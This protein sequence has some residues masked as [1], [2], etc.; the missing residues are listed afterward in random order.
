MNPSLLSN[1]FDN[2]RETTCPGGWLQPTENMTTSIVYG[3][4]ANLRRT[5]KSTDHPVS[6]MLKMFIG[7][8]ADT[9]IE[10]TLR[11]HIYSAYQMQHQSLKSTLL[12]QIRGLLN[13][14]PGWDGYDAKT[15]E[16]AAI[17]D[18]EQ[19]SSSILPNGD[20]A[21]P[22]VT[23]ASDGEVNFSWK[24]AL[25][26]IDLGFYGDGTYSYYIRFA[27]GEELISDESPLGESLPDNVIEIIRGN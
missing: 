13:L 20:F 10:S 18:A 2:I 23:A 8:Y 11:S 16:A 17:N 3:R 21:L 26:L 7:S 24:N 14:T 25:G 5:V 15:P 27:N 19:F 6:Q 22:V 9:K 4:A 12:A 1:P